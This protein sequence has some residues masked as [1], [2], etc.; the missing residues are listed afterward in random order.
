VLIPIYALVTTGLAAL[1]NS[2]P[3]YADENDEIGNRRLTL[4]QQLISVILL[5]AIALMAVTALVPPLAALWG[6]GWL[7]YIVV[8]LPFALAVLVLGE[9]VPKSVGASYAE[10]LAP[11]MRLLVNPVVYVLRPFTALIYSTSELVSRLFGSTEIASSITK[12]ELLTVIDAASQSF[13]EGERKMIHS[14]LELDETTVTEIMV[15]RIDIVAVEKDTSIAEA[16]KVFLESGHSRMPVFDDNIDNI[17]GLVYVKDLLE[18]WHNGH[19]VV[20]SVE[21]I[22]RPAHFIPEAMTADQLLH[23]FQRN[24][25]HMAIVVED[26][27]GTGGLVTLENLLEEIVGDIQD[28]YD[29]DEPEDIIQVGEN[30]YRV[31][32]GVAL[33]ELN[34]RLDVELSDEDVDTLGGFIFNQL[35]RVPEPGEVIETTHLDMRVIAVEGRRIREVHV[36]RREVVTDEDEPQEKE[37]PDADLDADAAEPSE[38]IA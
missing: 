30:E 21:E 3:E 12:E 11:T 9:I 19:T 6:N 8:L 23:E 18:V 31:D 5:F 2:R 29:E 10:Q 16:R 33:H 17:T 13:E 35:E 24:K 7:P 14:V 37:R 20:G 22:A 34:E 25:I 15:P 27:G 1:V 28:E 4:T 36:T 38:H 26:Y 32:A